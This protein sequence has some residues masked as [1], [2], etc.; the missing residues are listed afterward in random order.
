MDTAAISVKGVSKVYKLYRGRSKRLL[1]FFSLGFGEGRHDE[2][3]CALDNVSFEI[4]QGTTVGIIGRNGA[5]KSTLL[6]IPTGNS[7]PTKGEVEIKGKVSALLEIGTGF[8]PE[9][10]GQQNIHVSGVYLG[11]TQEEIDRLYTDIVAFSEL[12]DFI[13]QPVKTYSYGMYM[14]LAFSVSTCINPDVLII[15]EV[16]GVGDDYFS[17]KCFDRIR[18]FMECGKTVLMASHDFSALQRLCTRLLWIDHGRVV[19]DGSPLEVLKAY[20]ASIRKQEEKRIR[21]MI[22]ALQHDAH[23]LR[24]KGLIY[25]SGEIVITEVQCVNHEGQECHRFN[26]GESLTIRMRYKT[27]VPVVGPVFVAAIYRID[28]ITVCQAISSRDG[29][30]FDKLDG[31]G[32]VDVRFDRQLLGPGLYVISVAIFPSLDLLDQLGQTP[33]DL[34]DRLYEFQIEPLLDCAL[35]LGVV[36]HPVF[37]RHSRGA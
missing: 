23:S 16:L 7:S 25:G 27:K 31:Q 15:D 26:V 9:L 3:F 30:Q 4:P 22:P 18:S 2:E 8:H 5:G 37:W 12:E 6:R 14:R 32:I 36:L 20:A 34:H 28:G 19:M 17:R 11:L 21:T 33:Y 13:H 24:E 35:D 29:V 1:D 10:T